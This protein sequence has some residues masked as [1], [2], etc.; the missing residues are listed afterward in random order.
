MTISAEELAARLDPLHAIGYDEARG[1]NRLAWTAEDAAAGA[2]FEEQAAGAGLRAWRDAA[3][4]RWATPPGDGPWWA[5]GSH[6][7]S[8]R[9]GGAFDGALGVAAAFA[10]AAASPAPL[11]VISFA[12]EEGARFNTPTFGSRALTGV[13]DVEGVLA[14][15]DDDNISLADAMAAAGV[16]PAGLATAPEVLRH[17]RGFVEL[18]IDQSTD[19][20]AAGAPW[21]VV[22]SLAARLRLRATTTGTADHAGTT[23]M[24]GRQDALL[25]AARLITAAHDLCTPDMRATVGRLLVEPNA[26]TA[27]ATATTLWIDAR[28]PEATT[29]DP[30]LAA[31]T[32]G[33]AAEGAAFAIESRSPAVTFDAGL[34]ARL[35]A[36]APAGAV[37]PELVCWAGHDAGLLAPRVPAAMVL[38][39]NATGISHSPAEHVELDDAAAGAT[40]IL[41]ALS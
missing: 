17:L 32:T 6:T 37:T 27:I 18:H 29:L 24:D 16:D 30:W 9:D 4:N 8:V 38:V 7:D 25:R 34:R 31:L 3:G 2:W 14:R 26:L 13:L 39:R 36:A 40:A 19:L 23:P 41:H 10:I 20:A 12:D 28:A 22:A 15:T 35:A 11:A 5:V 1:T 21:G 33:A